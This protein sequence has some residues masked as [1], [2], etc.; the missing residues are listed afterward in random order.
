MG[1]GV[2]KA[3]AS[4]NEVQARQDQPTETKPKAPGTYPKQ[5]SQ[6]QVYFIKSLAKGA[7]FDDA[8]LHD[9]IAVTLDSDAVTLE[10]LNPDQ[11]TQIID[12][13]KKLPSSKGD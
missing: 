13:M 11:A 7:G 4:K 2:S 12:A 1:C 9:Y 8:A 3:I 6:K 5:A 10:T